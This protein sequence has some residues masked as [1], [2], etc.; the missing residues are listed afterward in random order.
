M[1]T[2]KCSLKL[3]IFLLLILAVPSGILAQ[4]SLLGKWKYSSP[5]GE[6]IMEINNN[7][8]LINGQTY[9]YKNENNILQVFEGNTYTSYPYRL[10]GNQLTLI[11]P[12]GM[13]VMFTREAGSSGGPLKLPQS[14]QKA[15]GGQSNQ[16]QSSSLI[17]RWVFQSQEGQM[18]LEFLSGNQLKYNGEPNQYQLKPGV[19]QAMGD[20]GWIDYP[21]TL[22]QNTLTLTTPEGI[23]IPFTRSS[24]A[25][26][27]QQ[28]MGG[29]PSGGQSSGAGPVWQLQGRLCYWSGSSSSYSS[30]SRTE[31]LS[32][33]GNGN[34][35]FGEEAGF[36]SD[37]GL[38]HS[39]NPGAWKGKYRVEKDYV[40]LRFQNGVENQVKIHMRQNDGRIT[41]LMYKNKLYAAALCE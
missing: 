13:E 11:F 21:Y 37:A 40:Y 29:Q 34:F 26:S 18:V 9:S 2:F 35:S 1:K 12:G 38:A 33:D 25:A 20:Y 7:A 17:G 39:N 32:F 24:S 36:S 27:P 23:Q 31:I 41:E 22:I 3:S 14:T 8:M 19:I 10:N 4:G 5:E 30:Y 6:M 28:S 16:S 15:P